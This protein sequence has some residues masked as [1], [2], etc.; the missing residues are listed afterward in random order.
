MAGIGEFE[1]NRIWQAA[2]RG[3]RVVFE[4]LVYR[5]ATTLE[6]QRRAEFLAEPHSRRGWKAETHADVP[7]T[8][9][10]ESVK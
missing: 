7:E 4:A 6:M 1:L 5:A 9:F 10:E 8:Q 2:Q 3:E